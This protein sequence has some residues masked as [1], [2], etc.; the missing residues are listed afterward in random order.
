MKKAIITGTLISLAGTVTTGYISYAQYSNSTISCPI[1]SLTGCATVT[2]S[3]YSHF[4][5]IPV[6]LIGFLTWVTLFFLSQKIYF[7]YKD[8]NVNP[9]YLWALYILTSIGVVAAGYFNSVMLLKLNAFCFWCETS[10]ALM[11]G[12]YFIASYM[13]LGNES[14]WLLKSASLALLLFLLPFTLTIGA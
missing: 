11:L 14:K 6:A 3:A 8:Q 10:H 1:D 13:T 4:G 9:N 12:K 7:Q 5:T 2:S